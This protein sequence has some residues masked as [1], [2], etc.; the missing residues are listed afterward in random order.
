MRAS[1]LDCSE[2][3]AREQ[4]KTHPWHRKMVPE[5]ILAIVLSSQEGRH[6]GDGLLSRYASL[7]GRRTCGGKGQESMV[8]DGP[9]GCA[10]H[11]F[12][13]L[14]DLTVGTSICAQPANL[15]LVPRKRIICH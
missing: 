13:G 9:A 1:S 6:L 11:P 5:G 3:E 8:K 4:A 12:R 2:G 7:T 15:S 10:L 14:C